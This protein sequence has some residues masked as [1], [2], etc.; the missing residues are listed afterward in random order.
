MIFRSNQRFL[1]VTFDPKKFGTDFGVTPLMDTFGKF[2]IDQDTGQP[3][4]APVL[5][6]TVKFEHGKYETDDKAEIAR[7]KAHPSC[8]GNLGAS[9]DFWAESEELTDATLQASGVILVRKPVDGFN[10]EH[11]EMLEYLHHWYNKRVAVDRHEELVA[12]FKE[13]L[14]CFRVI[15]IQAPA[16]DD[17]VRIL[18]SRIIEFFYQLEKANIWVA[19]DKEG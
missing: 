12:K 14:D 2:V 19:D 7:L 13:S 5:W 1:Y 15:G 3:T 10:S 6:P 9:D 17:G 8:E 11:V 4:K 18:K 16:V